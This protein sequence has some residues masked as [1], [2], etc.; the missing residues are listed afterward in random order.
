[1]IKFALVSNTD[2]Y[3]YNF[4]LSLAKTIKDNGDEVLLI[5]PG[6]AYAGKI[7]EQGFQWIEWQVGRQSTAPWLEMQ[8]IRNLTK[9]Y[10]HLRPDLVHH[11]TIKPVLYGGISARRAKLPSVVA[12][13]TGRGYTFSGEGIRP[14]I[15]EKIVRPFYSRVLQSDNTQIVFENE[16][17]QDYFIEAGF[18][19]SKQSHL[20]EGV[21]VDPEIFSYIPEPQEPVVVLLAS[22]MLWDKGV[23]VL[24]EAARLLQKNNLEFRLELV[25]DPDPGNPT[26]IPSGQL[27]DWEDENLLEWLGWQ[28]DM[29]RVFARCHIV[30]LPSFH[31]GVP[32]GLLEAAACG[33]P[34]IASDIPGCRTVVVDGIT[35]LLVPPRQAEPLAAA[36]ERLILDANLRGKMGKAGREH[37]L[38]NF[39]Q[40][41][42]NQKTLQVYR[43]ALSR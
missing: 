19:S 8:A 26:S 6:G 30:V 31:E 18:V 16:S 35:G 12:S 15:I 13:I 3:L 27:H 7:M 36:L 32:T 21:G 5:S 39:T 40:Q 24:V 34:I 43:L 14:K 11:H 10:K 42:I 25:G 9:I 23:G 41:Q 4:R 28:S 17:D 20:I 37:V 22:R 2:W 29:Q 1:M 33:R 38:K